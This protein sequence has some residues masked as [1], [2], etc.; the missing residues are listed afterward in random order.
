M[1]GWK[2]WMVIVPGIGLVIFATPIVFAYLSP[3]GLRGVYGGVREVTC[4][5]GHRFFDYIDHSGYYEL[6]PGHR[7]K[8]LLYTLQPQQSGEW[9]AFGVGTNTLAGTNT[10]RIRV[11]EG[12]V[13][14]T[15]HSNTKSIGWIEYTISGEYGF[16]GFC[17]SSAPALAS[18][19]P[20][21]RGSEQEAKQQGAGVCRVTSGQSRIRCALGLPGEIYSSCN[22]LKS[23]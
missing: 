20:R 17:H 1:R 21:L 9:I 4:M 8:E 7:S 18:E 10:F 3:H 5:C 23:C 11:S 14:R 22:W 16:H 19:L 6:V 15:V 12:E 2:K 13:Y